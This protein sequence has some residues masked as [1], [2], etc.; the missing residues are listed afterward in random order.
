VVEAVDHGLDELAEAM[1]L[2]F[3]PIETLHCTGVDA[4]HC[5]GVYLLHW[6]LHWWR[7][8]SGLA[9]ARRVG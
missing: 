6:S 5:T 7:W 8:A 4:V 3:K 1:D 9:L 2:V